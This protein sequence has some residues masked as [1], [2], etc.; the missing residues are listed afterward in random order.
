MQQE[1]NGLLSR[2]DEVSN[3]FFER[4]TFDIAICE[5]K[6]GINHSKILGIAKKSDSNDKFT[7]L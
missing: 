2:I 5:L 1:N 7:V 3:L 6:E 4:R